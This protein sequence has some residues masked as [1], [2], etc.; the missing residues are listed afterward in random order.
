MSQPLVIVFLPLSS[1]HLFFY[2]PD[3]IRFLNLLPLVNQILKTLSSKDLHV[4]REGKY[5]QKM[6]PLFTIEN[7]K[8]HV[9]LNTASPEVTFSSLTLTCCL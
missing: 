9:Y 3:P 1:L 8:L 4:T 2:Q 7:L 5:L 6:Y